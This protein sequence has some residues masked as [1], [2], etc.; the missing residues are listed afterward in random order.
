MTLLFLGSAVR[1]GSI[2]DI[3]A[4]PQGTLLAVICG[5]VTGFGAYVL[6]TL[7]MEQMETSRAAQLATIEPVTAAVLGSLLFHQPLSLFE[8]IG[9]ALV[10]LSVILMNV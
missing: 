6:Y 3:A 8:G 2:R 1:D 4:H 10:V 9:V 5:L 7:G